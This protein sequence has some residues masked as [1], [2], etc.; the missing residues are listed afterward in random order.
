M[1]RKTYLERLVHDYEKLTGEKGSYREKLNGVADLYRSMLTNM[2][3]TVGEDKMRGDFL[4]QECG[5]VQAFLKQ[6]LDGISRVY[7]IAR[8]F[9][10]HLARTTLDIPTSV[11][12]KFPGK[13]YLL[14]FPEGL[15]FN[16][17][18]NE[19]YTSCICTYGIMI[20]EPYHRFFFV[21]PKELAKLVL[22]D[23]VQVSLQI[24]ALDFSPA[25]SIVSLMVMDIST[26]DTIQKSI[27]HHIESYGEMSIPAEMVHYIVKCLLYIESGEPDLKS[28]G[29]FIETKNSKKQRALAHKDQYPFPVVRVG[30]GFH[31]RA[32]HVDS[33]MVSGH[34]RWQPYGPGMSK[35]KLIWIDEHERK[36]INHQSL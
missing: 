5:I 28:E 17:P 11:L 18:D 31:H 7:K 24:C 36:Y 9:G 19:S 23:K 26:K 30:Y 22:R 3:T 27:D 4:A 21:D 8:N 20:P 6:Y 14:E 29:V 13:T 2:A 34:F 12:P 32:W 33:T 15:T 10:G 16:G 35:V 1:R 25:D